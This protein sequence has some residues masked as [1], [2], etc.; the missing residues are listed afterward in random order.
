[1]EAGRVLL[2]G[3]EGGGAPLRPYRRIASVT[4]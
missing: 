4:E 3:W 1:M 2:F